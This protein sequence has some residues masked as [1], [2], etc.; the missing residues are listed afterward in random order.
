MAALQAEKLFEIGSM[1][2]TNSFVTAIFVTTIIIAIAF[3]YHR[4]ANLIPNK[5]TAFIEW[6]VEFLYISIENIAGKKAKT[7]FPLCATFFILII[8]NSWFGLLPFV[9]PIGINEIVDGKNEL[10]PLFRSLNADIN[11]TFVLAL[12]S[13]IMTNFF[14]VRSVGIRNHIGH[15]MLF[16]MLKLFQI[17]RA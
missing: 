6:V 7:F 16:F 9:G 5:F 14:D 8:V 13:V 12:V 1:P 11:G 15:Y 17:S 10:V 4:Q 3:I 2:I